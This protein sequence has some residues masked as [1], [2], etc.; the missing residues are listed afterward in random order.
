MCGGNHVEERKHVQERK[1]IQEQ[2]HARVGSNRTELER[3]SDAGDFDI[4]LLARL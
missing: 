1:Y 4:R 3:G 2:G